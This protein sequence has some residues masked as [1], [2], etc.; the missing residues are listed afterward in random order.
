MP[1]D[2]RSLTVRRWPVADVDLVVDERRMQVDYDRRS[3]GTP[4][5]GLGVDFAVRQGLE[6]RV[7]GKT[8]LWL[9][10]FRVVVTDEVRAR[11][12][13]E[14]G[15]FIGDMG[16][17]PRHTRHTDTRGA[18]RLPPALLDARDVPTVSVDVEVA[19]LAVHRPLEDLDLRVRRSKSL[20]QRLGGEARVVGGNPLDRPAEHRVTR[21]DRAYLAWRHQ[22]IVRRAPRRRDPGGATT[23]YRLL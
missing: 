21:R 10:E 14:R 5:D 19:L 8:R 23:D 16:E 18:R 4:D 2:R 7:G 13:H 17:P 3:V 9:H 12:M 6:H 15:P 22:P 1:I 11:G 20:A